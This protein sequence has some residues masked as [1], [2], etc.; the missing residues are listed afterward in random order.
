MIKVIDRVEVIKLLAK[1]RLSESSDD[2]IYGLVQF[3]PS[4]DEKEKEV[5]EALVHEYQGVT[6]GF[7]ADVYEALTG[8]R[9]EVIGNVA[10]LYPCPCCGLKTLTELYD[11]NEG[12]GYD[13]C[14]Y[15]W[16]EDVGVF[17]VDRRVSVNRGSIADYRERISLNRNRYYSFKW[18]AGDQS[19][20]AESTLSDGTS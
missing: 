19:Y 13:V 5:E 16:W 15:C 12:T 7:L 20:T 2:E 1:V 17:E 18:R 3:H 6:N 8:R 9:V 14:R 4:V 10:D 11:L